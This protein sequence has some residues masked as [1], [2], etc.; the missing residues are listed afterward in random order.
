VTVVQTSS[1]K[2]DL[3][4]SSVLLV[5]DNQQSLDLMQQILTGFRVGNIRTCVDPAE[6]RDIA[7]RN[8]FN[9]LIIDGEMPNED[10]IAVT[11]HVRANADLP[12]FSAPI[13]LVSAHTPMEKVFKARDAGANLIIKKPIAPAVLLSRIQWLG[14]NTRPFII[15]DTY[16]GPDRRIKNMPLPEGVS[17]RRAQAIA[18][19]ANAEREMSQ[20]EVD[21]LFG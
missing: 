14:R 4:R 18:L 21:S 1:G 2:I 10:G 19:T 16:C 11:R 17:E 5:D 9:L 13:I 8:R 20:D 15:S 6:S 3:T 7:A 12:N